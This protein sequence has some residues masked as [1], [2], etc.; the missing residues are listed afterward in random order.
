MAETVLL[1]IPR[2]PP[3][4]YNRIK[5]MHWAKVRKLKQMWQDEV[6]VASIQQGKPKFKKARIQIVLYYSQ[7]RRRDSDNLMA[8]AG[9]FILDGLRYAEIIPDDD[10]STIECPEP[11][12]ELDRK[13]PRVEIEITSL[14]DE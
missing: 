12:V 6:A 1:V 10:Q 13:K 4:T 8:G 9:K 5:S 2:K 7:A 3:P 14:D 11:I